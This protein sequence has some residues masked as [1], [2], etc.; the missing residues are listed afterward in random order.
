MEMGLVV[1]WELRRCG[2]EWEGKGRRK[3]G[4]VGISHRRHTLNGLWNHGS[5]YGPLDLE[6]SNVVPQGSHSECNPETPRMILVRGCRTESYRI[7]V[8]VGL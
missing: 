8:M 2:G 3:G 6:M 5:P 4:T 1:G 7:H